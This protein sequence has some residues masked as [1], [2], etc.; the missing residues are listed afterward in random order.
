MDS[1]LDVAYIFDSNSLSNLILHLANR[2]R[3]LFYLVWPS[4]TMFSSLDQVP[5][6]VAEV[7]TPEVG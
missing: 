3:L 5:R 4:E 2:M 6:Y 7:S 1:L